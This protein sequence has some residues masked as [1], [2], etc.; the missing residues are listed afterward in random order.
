MPGFS[1]A[2]YCSGQVLSA[3]LHPAGIVDR[4]DQKSPDYFLDWAFEEAKQVAEK[5]GVHTMSVQAHRYFDVWGGLERGFTVLDMAAAP[6]KDA[7]WDVAT[8][9]TSEQLTDAAPAVLA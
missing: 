8:K 5:V 6:P 7:P 3:R 1:R 4:G 9:A 2:A